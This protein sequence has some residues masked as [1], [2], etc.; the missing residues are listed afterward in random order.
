MAGLAV[1][2]EACLDV[3]DRGCVDVCPVQC[4]YEFDPTE[5]V[6]FSEDEAGSGE[7]AD[8]PGHEFRAFVVLAE[9]V[10]QAGVGIGAD[11]RV[12]D[13]ADVGDVGAQI[14]TPRRSAS[15]ATPSS[16]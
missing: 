1:I 10:G 4:I 2:T 12:G 9:L 16:T 15:S 8:Q 3:K 6:L 13:A 14:L 7:F 5:N 11:Q